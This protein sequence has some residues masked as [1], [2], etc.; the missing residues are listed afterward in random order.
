MRIISQNGVANINYDM[1]HLYKDRAKSP[2]PPQFAIIAWEGWRGSEFILG[3]YTTEEQLDAVFEDIVMV[4]TSDK[5]VYR[6]PE[7]EG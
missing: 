1:V 3:A 4:G 5:K 7:D 6:M 2:K